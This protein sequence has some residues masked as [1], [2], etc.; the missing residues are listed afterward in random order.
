[1]AILFFTQ[2][3]ITLLARF[4]AKFIFFNS[5]ASFPV[6]FTIKYFEL[7][8]NKLKRLLTSLNKNNV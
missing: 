1:M 2:F 5:A 4:I 8:L 3:R 6:I 7:K